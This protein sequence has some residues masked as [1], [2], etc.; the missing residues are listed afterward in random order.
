MMLMM[1]IRILMVMLTTTTMMMLMMMIMTMTMLMMMMMMIMM[2]MTVMT[3]MIIMM[4]TVTMM[5][6]MLLMMT[7]I[8][9]VMMI[10]MMMMMVMAAAFRK[11]LQHIRQLVEWP[12]WPVRSVPPSR[13]QPYGLPCTPNGGYPKTELC[14]S[15]WLASNVLSGIHN[16]NA[17]TMCLPACLPACQP[18]Y[19]P[20]CQ[21]AWLLDSGRPTKHVIDKSPTC[22]ST[23]I[24]ALALLCVLLCTM[25]AQVCTQL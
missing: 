21:P 25:F 20:T 14:V 1:G 22:T 11:C 12:V 16:H 8:M 24:N 6:M 4:M 10:M 15:G 17:T 7:M 3:I 13:G 2:M 5:M 9:M 23:I 18:T 19:L